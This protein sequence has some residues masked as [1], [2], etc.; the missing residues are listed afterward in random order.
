[1]FELAKTYQIHH[2]SKTCRKYR[3]EKCRFNFGKFFTS[4][5]I[6]GQPLKDHIPQDVRPDQMQRRN[7]I[8][9]RVKSYIDDELNPSKKSFLESSKEDYVELKSI[10]E[11]LE[12]LEISNEDY[13]EPFS[14]SDCNNIQMHYKKLPDSCF[15]N[16]YF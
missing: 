8:L 11:I 10:D 12:I 7:A 15:I 13:E 3:N 2:H 4:H 5:A 1:M 14:I 6:I 9:K 16:N